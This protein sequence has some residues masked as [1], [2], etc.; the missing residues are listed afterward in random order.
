VKAAGRGRGL[1]ILAI[2]FL[3]LDGVLLDLVG[4]WTRRW[5]L[6][7]LGGV[8]LLVAWG[9]AL[10]WRRQRSR[11]EEIAAARAEL[12]SEVVHLRALLRSPHSEGPPT[13]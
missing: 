13:R 2:G 4:W 3:T 6:V 5:G 12:K 10:L 9:V 11:L 7:A 1:T 8:L